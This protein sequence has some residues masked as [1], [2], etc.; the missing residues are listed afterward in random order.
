[1]A[2][3]AAA[4]SNRRFVFL[5]NLFDGLRRRAP[6]PEQTMSMTRHA[7]PAST[8]SPAISAPADWAS[9]SWVLSAA[10]SVR[11]ENAAQ[12]RDGDRRWRG[13]HHYGA[14]RPEA[15]NRDLVAHRRLVEGCAREAEDV[16]FDA[17]G[18]LDTGF[19][20]GQI[21]RFQ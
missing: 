1:M 11:D 7:V 17:A 8:R 10:A 21:V 5:Q 9:R 2:E 18:F 14:G 15:V 12:S 6:L 4:T 20:N 16:A 3:A 19:A 13:T